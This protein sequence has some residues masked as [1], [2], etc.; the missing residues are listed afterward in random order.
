M[1]IEHNRRRLWVNLCDTIPGLMMR[2][3]ILHVMFGPLRVA[4]IL[5]FVN[6]FS[7]GC[8]E[9]HQPNNDCQPGAMSPAV[10]KTASG[11]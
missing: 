2:K 6:P 8:A 4:H 9:G 11:V 1:I 10:R 5:H 7:T 3:R